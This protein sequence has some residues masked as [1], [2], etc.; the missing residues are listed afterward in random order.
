MKGG[1]LFGR[2]TDLDRGCWRQVVNKI[3]EGGTT[4]FRVLF[5]N[6]SN[7]SHP[8]FWLFVPQSLK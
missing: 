5:G 8:K 7:D 3:S 2:P 6:Q 1:K 4:S